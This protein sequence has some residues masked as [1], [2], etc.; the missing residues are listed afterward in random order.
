MTAQAGLAGRTERDGQPRR[1]RLAAGLIVGFECVCRG[2]L[3]GADVA[4][5]AEGAADKRWGRPD[6]K[7]L[8]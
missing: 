4:I 5:L 6:S 3:P 1:E 7:I 2:R 8:E